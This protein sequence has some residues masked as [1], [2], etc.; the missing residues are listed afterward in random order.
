MIS[1]RIGN[2]RMLSDIIETEPWGF[3]SRNFFLNQVV[4]VETDAPAGTILA[5]TQAIEKEMGRSEKSRNGIYKDRII[6]IDLLLYGNLIVNSKRLTLPHPKMALR[7]FVLEPLAQI[8][9][10]VIHPVLKKDIK[11]LLHNIS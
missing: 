6:D 2:V 8:A 9:P 5:Q 7:R 11:E 1:E 4:A 10:D 3:A